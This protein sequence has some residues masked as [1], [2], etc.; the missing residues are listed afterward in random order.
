MLKIE[1]FTH[2]W[3]NI[4]RWKR[5]VISKM[6]LVPFL[7]HWQN[8]C[9]ILFPAIAVDKN[10]CGSLVNNGAMESAASFSILQLIPSSLVALDVSRLCRISNVFAWDM[11]MKANLELVLYAMSENLHLRCHLKNALLKFSNLSQFSTRRASPMFGTQ[12]YLGYHTGWTISQSSLRTKFH[13]LCKSPDFLIKHKIPWA[14]TSWSCLVF[15]VPNWELS[16][17]SSWTNYFQGMNS[18]SGQP[19]AF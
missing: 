14:W 13:D 3:T 17:S 15:F 2:L 9:Y 7:K 10:N 19:I 18:A 4:T 5:S 16:L 8:I 6:R 11:L 12:E 1:F